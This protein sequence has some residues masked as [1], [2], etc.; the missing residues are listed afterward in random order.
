[1]TI[2]KD[3]LGVAAGLFGGVSRGTFGRHLLFRPEIL[4]LGGIDPGGDK[5]LRGIVNL[6]RIG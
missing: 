3:F 4:A 5:L 6:F 2:A 1:M